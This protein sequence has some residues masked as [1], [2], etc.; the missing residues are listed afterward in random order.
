MGEKGAWVFQRW[1]RDQIARDV[2]LD[3]LVRRIVAGLGSTWQNPPSS[4]YRTNRD[5]TT[6]AESV[7]QVFLGIRLQCARCHNH[8]FDVWTQD[9][10]YGLAAFFANIARKQ[11]NNVRKDRPRLARDQRR[12]DHL[13]DRPPRDGPAADRRRPATEVPERAGRRST[14]RRRRKR[15]RSAG[16][17]ADAQQ[18]PVQPE[19]GQPGLVPPARPGDRRAGRRFP[20]LEPARPTP[21]FWTRSTA[22]FEAD[23]MRLKPLVAWIMK[24]RTYQLSATPDADQRRATSRISRTRPFELLPAEVLLDA[25]SQVLAVPER[26]PHA[27]SSLRAAQLPGPAR[28]RRVLEDVRQARP[29]A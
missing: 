22:H 25:I 6:A 15:P 10:Y 12:R 20:R 9:D 5:P 13:P 16:R 21:R 23:G 3:E 8:P 28:R 24:S 27:P 7:G 29:A 2:P 14:R 4:F 18:P 26:F 1:L 17:L 19:P 11:P